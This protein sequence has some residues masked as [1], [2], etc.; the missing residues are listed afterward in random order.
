LPP[1]SDK[2]LNLA[3]GSSKLE[4]Y[5]EILRTVAFNDS[6]RLNNYPHT[7]SG[8][9][10][11]S[12]EFNRIIDFLLAQHVIRTRIDAEGHTL[13]SITMRGKKILSYFKLLPKINWIKDIE[14]QQDYTQM[15]SNRKQPPK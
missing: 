11:T 9:C 2:S 3:E 13:C 6:Y 5:I 1:V 15:K 14:E 12:Q 4:T 8:K 7:C 10:Q